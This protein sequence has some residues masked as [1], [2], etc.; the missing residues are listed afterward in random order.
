M[1]NNE[2]V[3]VFGKYVGDNNKINVSYIGKRED[4]I[5]KVRTEIFNLKYGRIAMTQIIFALSIAYFI[6]NK[7]EF[8]DWK[9]KNSIKRSV[10]Y[11][12]K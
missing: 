8:R 5:N 3:A 2:N 9:Y 4:V 1:L 7:Y 11:H 10:F 6:F 12:P